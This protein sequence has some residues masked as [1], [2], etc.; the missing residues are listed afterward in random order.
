[1][2]D[3]LASLDQTLLLWVNSF[4]SDT[5][6]PIISFLSRSRLVWCPLYLFIIYGMIRRFGW[7]RGLI[8]VAAAALAVG[9]SDYICASVIRP[10]VQRL[11]PSNPDN[12]ISSMVH[13]VNGYRS[14]R[15]T[16]PSCHGANCFCLAVF[17]SLTFRRRWITVAMMLWAVFMCYT[18][19]YLG[20][21]YPGDLLTGGAIG[22]IFAI[23]CYAASNKINKRLVVAAAIMTVTT[24]GISAQEAADTSDKPKFEWSVDFRGVF[25]N[26][27]CDNTYTPTGTYFITQLAPEVGVSFND[28]RH[29][30]SGG[31]VYTQPIGCEWD[32]HRV[33]PTLYYRYKTPSV[34][35]AI[36]MIPRR[37][38]VREL[39]NYIQ[40]D[41]ASYFQSNIRGAMVTLERKNGFFQALIDWRGMQS[42]N[43]REAFHMIAQGE[44]H[45]PDK[46]FLAGGLL[47]LN[48]LAKR[49]NAPIDEFVVDNIIAQPYVGTDFSSLVSPLDSLALRVGPITSLTRDRGDNKWIAPI[50][51][52]VDF[53]IGW[54]RLQLDNTLYI[55]NK[56]LFPLHDRFGCLLNS[57]ESMYAAKFYNRTTVKGDIFSYK[58][59]VHL[60]VALDF[61]VA[62]GKFTFYQRLLLKV[63]I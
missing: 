14:G 24:T 8:Y 22:T 59:M 18:R 4:H 11:R 43:R 36:G 16:F 52:Y 57:G 13:L 50:G 25:D 7:K 39:P 12:P 32:G 58:N 41:S 46:I 33:S 51:A 62:E 55:G 61:H 42:E 19:M 31:V 26:R 48:H 28:S 6:D 49:K 20:V 47:M 44:W 30:I 21:H 5:A 29:L 9:L 63:T 35:Y 54:W 17:V 60:D 3:T 45:R 1:M 37:Q 53:T 2:L 23:I 27:E 38:L 15:Y 10:A 34:S 40:S 56:P